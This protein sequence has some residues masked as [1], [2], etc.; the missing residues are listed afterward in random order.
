MLERTRQLCQIAKPV[1]WRLEN[2]RSVLQL[3]AMFWAQP[4]AIIWSSSVYSHQKK[5]DKSRS[6]IFNV[7]SILATCKPDTARSHIHHQSITI[8]RKSDTSLYFSL[9]A[10]V[11]EKAA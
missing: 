7:Q 9:S 8:F 1:M 4:M 10:H 2:G 11:P 5:G 6:G 3:Y